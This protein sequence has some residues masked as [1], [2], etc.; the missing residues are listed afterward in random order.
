M[1]DNLKLIEERIDVDIDPNGA[2][3][4]ILAE[5]HNGIDKE[6]LRKT[7]KYTGSPFVAKKE[8]TLFPSGTFSWN[9]NA[10][11]NTASFVITTSKLSSDL[12]DFGRDLQTLV[13]G[14]LMQFKDYSGRSVHLEFQSF[15]ANTDG[16]M[17]P[18]YN[19]TVKG[20]ADSLNYVY[21]VN[22]TSISVLSLIKKIVGIPDVPGL[23]AV[24]DSK[25]DE[26]AYN[27]RFKG[28]YASL[29]NLQAAHPTGNDGDYAI[30]DAG[31]GIAA[32]EYIWD[33]SEGWV[34]GNS[35]GASTTD[36][37][38]EGSSNLYFTTA[39]VLASLL[40]GISFVTGGSIVSTDSVLTAFGKLQKQIN[41]VIVSVGLKEGS[42]NKQNSLSI[43]GTGIKYPTVDAVNKRTPYITF[44]EFGAVGDGIVDDSISVQNAVNY[45]SANG[46]TILVSS[47]TFVCGNINLYSN[48]NLIGQ[49]KNS[50]L[51]FK[52]GATYIL[53]VNSGSGGT[54]DISNNIKNINIQKISFVGRNQEDGFSEHKHLLNL[55]AASFI[56]VDNCS[57]TAFQGDAIYIGSSNTGG[58][59]RHNTN[60]TITNS[61]FDGI[62]KQ[63]RNA[64][65][66]IDCNRL[67]VFNCKFFNTTKTTMPGAIDLEPDLNAFAIIRNIT[68]S[69]NYF[70]NI[71]GNV[72]TIC[73]ILGLSQETLTVSAGNILVSNN[74]IESSNGLTFTQ[75]TAGLLDTTNNINL[76]LINNSVTNCG[77][78]ILNLGNLKGVEVSGNSFVNSFNSALIGYTASSMKDVKIKNNIFKKIGSSLGT[79][80]NIFTANRLSLEGNLFEDCYGYAIDFNGL[81]TSSYISLLNNIITSPTGL[82]TWAIQKEANHT[83]TTS[84]NS[85][86]GNKLIGVSGNS[87]TYF[88]TDSS[89][90]GTTGTYPKFL[91]G[92]ALGNSLVS[93]NG[94]IV[95]TNGFVKT[96]V[97]TGGVING[98]NAEKVLTMPSWSTSADINRDIIIGNFGIAGRIQVVLTGSFGTGDA[99][100]CIIKE[101]VI[102]ANA[103]NAFFTNKGNVTYANGSI[104][105]QYVIGGIYWDATNSVYAIRISKLIGSTN[106]NLR[107]KVLVQSTVNVAAIIASVS[108]G[109]EYTSTALTRNFVNLPNNTGIGT[110]SAQSSTSYIPIVPVSNLHTAENSSVT[111]AAA[112]HTVEQGGSGD[113]VTQYLLSGGQ[114]WVAGIDNSDGDKYKIGSGELGSADK[115]IID[116]TSGD[117]GI[118][119]RITSGTTVLNNLPPTANNHLVRKDYIELI[120]SSGS[121]TPTLTN[122]TNVTGAANMTATYVKIGDIVTV[123][124]SIT[125]TVTTAATLTVITGTLPINR[126]S[127]ISDLVGSGIAVPSGFASADPCRFQMANNTTQFTISCVP[128]ANGVY[129]FNGSF[130]YKIT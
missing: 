114:R 45:L 47:K 33:S 2:P 81:A 125:A 69:D 99:G 5:N 91:G 78:Y 75:N 111:N 115:V 122:T 22:E 102:E 8:S 82:T 83:L 79:G 48:I 105:S 23:Q 77:G 17:N 76:K 38:P 117:V 1:S 6:I 119:G 63:N 54:T 127:I 128:T 21:Q 58:L 27:D 19:I 112:G 101:F 80:I 64:I 103:N 44:E 39:R 95:T 73:M 62:D 124:V 110:A 94:S 104:V 53:S 67:L 14:D 72:G 49:S 90:I 88:F 107:A 34:L 57:F 106:S 11:N 74:I 126:V 113:A 25:L 13:T 68:I 65:S 86:I 108:V 51:K 35:M 40:T 66:V 32:V 97:S 56:K 28:K 70:Y 46:G 109:S 98:D 24:L 92:S 50:I 123:Y 129:G 84:T 60:I 121:S 4:S 9:G 7:G 116:P 52:S 15:V 12:V 118:A 36:S 61:F 16:S 41:D 100:G 87:F 59:E 130:S 26:S 29:A 89:I 10:M 3:G 18:I 31:A 42:S 120:V 71:G 43:D 30:V 93:E 85:Y 96:P 37:L 55:N 20:F